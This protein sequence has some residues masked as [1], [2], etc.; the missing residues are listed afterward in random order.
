VIAG[1]KKPRLLSALGQEIVGPGYTPGPIRARRGLHGRINP[2]R[3]KQQGA[4]HKN[5]VTG[6]RTAERS[7][8]REHGG[9]CESGAPSKAA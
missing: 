5:D 9:A 8:Q 3:H 6:E 4:A 2:D 1:I 7:C